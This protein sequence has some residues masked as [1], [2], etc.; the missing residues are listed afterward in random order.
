MKAFLNTSNRVPNLLFLSHNTAKLSGRSKAKRPTRTNTI[1]HT[2]HGLVPLGVV[3]LRGRVGL[4]LVV[5]AAAESGRRGGLREPDGRLP[6]LA[7]ASARALE[8]AVPVLLR[9]LALQVR[10]LRRREAGGGVAPGLAGVGLLLLPSSHG[11]WVD[12]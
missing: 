4:L 11:R 6:E 10:R 3:R 9:R 12:R 5:V 2:W 8:R 1:R 7:R